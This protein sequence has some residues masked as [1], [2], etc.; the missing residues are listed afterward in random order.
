[1]MVRRRAADREIAARIQRRV[2]IA[3]DAVEA[4]DAV[5]VQVFSAG[6][7]R[8]G[9]IASHGDHVAFDQ[10]SPRAPEFVVAS[11]IIAETV[12]SDHPETSLGD[13]QRTVSCIGERVAL[14]QE[15]RAGLQV[16]HIAP[17]MVSGKQIADQ[18]Q[19]LAVADHAAGPA[20]GELEV[21]ILDRDRLAVFD[22]KPSRL[23]AP[24]HMQPIQLDVFQP[25]QHDD[26]PPARL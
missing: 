26:R 14:D 2:E 6:V 9:A 24:G 20:A 25:V 11:P 19:L 3:V 5:M 18:S 17:K 10:Q 12:G 7:G 22:P 15:M 21:A 1:M 4:E 16:D 13:L 23:F 8:P